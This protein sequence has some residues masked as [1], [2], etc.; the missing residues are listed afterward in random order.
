[1]VIK[2]KQT[3]WTS[4]VIIQRR[5]KALKISLCCSSLCSMLTKDDEI[6]RETLGKRDEMQRNE[7]EFLIEIIVLFL[8]V[9]K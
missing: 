5:L 6:L 2:Y 4:I 8:A 9:S 7:N 3:G 1:M